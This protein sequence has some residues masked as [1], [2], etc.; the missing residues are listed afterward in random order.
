[1][2]EL[3][4]TGTVKWF[5][6]TKGYGFLATTS[7]GD[8]FVH[9]SALAEGRTALQA[10][11]QVICG[12]RQGKK[13]QVACDVY[14]TEPAPARPAPAERDAETASVVAEI[15]AQLGESTAEVQQK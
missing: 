12:V 6:A 10:G 15:A 11:D 8:L 9:V 3:P 4:I 7:H 14:V 2:T 13:G 5:N 1:M